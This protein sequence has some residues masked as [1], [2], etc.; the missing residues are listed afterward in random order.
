MGDQ[1]AHPYTVDAGERWI[2][3]ATASDPVTQ[4]AI[5][6]DGRL[7]GGL[8]GFPMHAEATG[9][10][11]IGWWLH[12][13]CWGRGI[14]TACVVALIDEFLGRGMMRVWAP[15]MAPNRASARVAEKAGMRFEG[16]ARSHYL[17]AGV[18]HD[19]LHYGLTRR[20]W[21]DARASG[22]TRS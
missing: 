21:L 3:M 19:A 2:E 14:M 20:Q 7:V 4:Y 5:H 17:K 13:D 1:F 10:C 9:T 6:V 16:T 18:R 12:P 8:G 11:E 22:T 15:I